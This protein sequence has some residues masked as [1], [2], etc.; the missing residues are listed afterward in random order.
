MDNLSRPD[1]LGADGAKAYYDEWRKIGKVEL[2]GN[3]ASLFDEAD[4]MV[5]DC[6]SFLAEFGATGKPIVYLVRSHPDAQMPNAPNRYFDSYYK[7]R[8]LEE[9]Y[10][11]FKSVLEE[12]RDPK[13]EERRKAVEAAGLMMDDAAKRIV[14]WLRKL[15]ANA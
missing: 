12:S 10:E 1:V 15:C 4:A 2:G 11:A 8:N 9:M 13:R 14:E 5:T 7:A 3:Y 6:G